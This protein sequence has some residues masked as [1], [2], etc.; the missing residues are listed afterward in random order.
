MCDGYW[1]SIKQSESAEP[2]LRISEAIVLERERRARKNLP[3]IDEVDAV[4]LEVLQPF[5]FVPLE[6][7][8]QNVYTLCTKCKPGSQ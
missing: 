2:P 6:P 4:V 1:N 3:R 7:H 5:R 8:L